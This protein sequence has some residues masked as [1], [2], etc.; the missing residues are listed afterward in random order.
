LSAITRV[1]QPEPLH[2]HGVRGD[3]SVKKKTEYAAT[4]HFGNTVVHIVAPP[5]MSEEQVNKIL[6]EHHR[7][8][9]SILEELEEKKRQ[10]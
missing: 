1:V 7:I 2:R 4:Y 3:A 5:P 6:K 8:G 9:W 10:Q